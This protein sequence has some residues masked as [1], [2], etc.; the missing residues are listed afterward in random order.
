MADRCIKQ[1]A[2]VTSLASSFAVATRLR[3][4]H[5]AFSA[6]APNPGMVE[7]TREAEW[8]PR[9]LETELEHGPIHSHKKRCVSAIR[10]PRRAQALASLSEGETNRLDES[11]SWVS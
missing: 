5:P 11:R 9:G 8:P 2:R 6:E 1:T 10:M 3:L 7:A 4:G